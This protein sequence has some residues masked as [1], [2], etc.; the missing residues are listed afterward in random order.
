MHSKKSM[1]YNTILL[2]MTYYNGIL[3]ITD[4]VISMDKK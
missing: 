4:H 1:N 3:L 2:C